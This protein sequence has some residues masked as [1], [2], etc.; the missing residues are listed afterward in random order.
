MSKQNKVAKV[1]V[2]QA[3]GLPLM[4][5]SR[6]DPKDI[7]NNLCGSPICRTSYNSYV[8]LSCRKTRIEMEMER[9]ALRC[10]LKSILAELGY[11]NTYAHD[12]NSLQINHLKKL[13]S[14]YEAL[15]KKY[16]DGVDYFKRSLVKASK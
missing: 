9:H 15:L 5:R 4:Y 3:C 13:V 2:C 7:E 10:R 6:N 12:I 8:V 16:P 1:K 14:D 11:G